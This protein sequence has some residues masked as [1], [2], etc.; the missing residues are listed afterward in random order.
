MLPWPVAV[1]LIALINLVG[2]G[3][4]LSHVDFNNAP[5]LYFPKDAPS[6][7]INDRVRAEFPND[8]FLIGVFE[9]PDLYSDRVLKGLDQISRQVARDK[10]VDRVFS[11]TNF[12]HITGTDDGFAVER[13][14]DPEK[15]S[16]LSPEA[17]KARVLGDRFAPGLVAAKDGSALAI[18]VRPKTLHH[19]RERVAIEDA[20]HAAVQEAGLADHL[21]AVAGPI[22]L[23]TAQL[24][25]MLV[26][27]AANL[28]VT[29]TIAI[30]LMAWVVGRAAPVIIGAIAMSTVVTISV[31]TLAVIGQPYTLVTAM[32]PPLLAAYTSAT[33][34]HLYAALFRMRRA[35][36]R[37]PRRV[38]MAIKEVHK[39]SLFNILTT[40]AGMASFVLTPIPPIQ[41]FG[42]VGTVATLV[43]YLVVFHL[44]PPLLVKWDTGPWPRRGGGFRWTRKVAFG[45]ASFAMRRAGITVAAIAV[46][47]LAAVPLLGKIHVESD[48]LRFFQADHP[49]TRST[50]IMEAKL[51]GATALVVFF[52]GQRDTFKDPAVL[53]AMAEFERWA[54]A[55]PEVDRAVSMASLVEDMNWAFHG[56]DPAYRRVPDKRKLVSQLLLV[57]DGN[58][59]QEM[60][61]RD[62]SRSRM[63]L[64]LNVHGAHQIRAVIE[65][66]NAQLKAHPIPGV[67]ADT[68]GYGR[69]FS[70][71]E[72][73]LVMGQVKSFSGAFLQIFLLLALLWRS[74]TAAAICMAP[75]L[76]PLYFIFV[77]MGVTGITLDMATSLIAA[78][79]LGI[80]V[81]DT[82]HLYHS[83]KHRLEAGCSHTYALAR[84]FEASGRAVIA[85]TL[86]IT[87]QFLLLM[88]SRFT[89]TEDFGMLAAAGLIAGQAFE[90]LLL[91]ALLVL[92]DR[93]RKRAAQ[94]A[95]DARHPRQAAARGGRQ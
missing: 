62:Y 21:V 64:S 60:V 58:D 6:V 63:G 12:D 22:P 80:T 10:L 42:L 46:L 47:V 40:G 32:I 19:S 59:L 87:A 17:R 28:P 68:A 82:I 66:L 11:V 73:L 54:E 18:L 71:Q 15:L 65:K 13:L 81:D 89:P 94:R 50:E 44:V 27:T 51:S 70:D 52:E 29:F 31:A 24:R 49:L 16:E 53:Q 78:V 77:L 38:I 72:E 92:W 23:D 36:M 76:A 8:E 45:L 7:Q 93:R 48:L 75:N 26:D 14:L 34:L 33:L 30:A 2:G 9:G 79:I 84:S 90:L 69:L 1:A 85:V 83:Y 95:W 55:L 25:S 88:G 74:F 5:E 35:G 20:F 43:V 86:V 41:V 3:L 91:P 61:N 37:R 67:H 56:E 39:A 57:Y 4:L